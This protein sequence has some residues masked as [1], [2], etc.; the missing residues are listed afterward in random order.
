[1]KGR[2]LWVC[3][4]LR[5]HHWGGTGVL[6]GR[7]GRRF[8]AASDDAGA[9]GAAASGS[10]F[11]VC[12]GAFVMGGGVVQGRAWGANL[13]GTAARAFGALGLG[14]GRVDAR[15][16]ALALED[17]G[18]GGDDGGLV[19]QR[20]CGC[21]FGGGRCGRD[22]EETL[23]LPLPLGVERK[24]VGR[25]R[26]GKKRRKK[27]RKWGK[28]RKDKWKKGQVEGRAMRKGTRECCF[29]QRASARGAVM[30]NT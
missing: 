3:K 21:R 24:E 25:K 27:G 26:R 14:L 20:R 7:P 1:M 12:A 9:C 22:R 17:L 19:R 16:A 4:G 2:C 23:G 29:T 10:G 30:T 6:R 5:G 28:K 11:C 18:A 15:A 8:P 13:A